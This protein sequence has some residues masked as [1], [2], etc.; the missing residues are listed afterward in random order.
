MD[1]D[2]TLTNTVNTAKVDGDRLFISTGTLNVN[3]GKTFTIISTNRNWA[4]ASGMLELGNANIRGTLHL[5]VNA[6][7][8]SIDNGKTTTLYGTGILD[9]ATDISSYENILR[10]VGTFNV[11]SDAAKA[12]VRFKVYD[13]RSNSGNN[14]VANLNAAFAMAS[15]ATTWNSKIILRNNNAG[16]KLTFNLGASQQFGSLEYM[17]NTLSSTNFTVDFT[18]TNAVIIL[19]KIL[20]N[21]TTTAYLTLKNFQNDRFFIQDITGLTLT[22]DIINDKLQIVA[23]D[24]SSETVSDLSFV[25]G[26]TLDATGAT[27]SGYWLNAPIP[28]PAEWAA[29]FGALA[30]GF[31][32]FRKRSK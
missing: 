26:T 16:G 29:I 7:C 3:E 20:M 10:F 23:T 24:R 31:A 8:F 9:G 27:I 21:D 5:K 1:T 22:D 18:G 2:F 17:T 11:E 28:E 25:A 32:F 6:G 19:S 15:S 13:S 14:P 4:T 30:L 12:S